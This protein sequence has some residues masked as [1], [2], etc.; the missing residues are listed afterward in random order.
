MIPMGNQLSTHGGSMDRNYSRALWVTHGAGSRMRHV[1]HDE[2]HAFVVLAH[3][4]TMNHGPP[5]GRP[6]VYSTEPR[7]AHGYVMSLPWI[8]DGSPLV[9]HE[10]LMG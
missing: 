5:M 10:S 8:G 7:G 9:S 6:W 4:S 3:G 2:S 1:V